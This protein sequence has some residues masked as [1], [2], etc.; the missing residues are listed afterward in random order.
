MRFHEVLETC[1]PRFLLQQSGDDTHTGG[2]ASD[3]WLVETI[4]AGNVY[5][6]R[7]LHVSSEPADW[8][9]NC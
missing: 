5:E 4:G 1:A 8:P 3:Q 6:M 9:V 2:G 7:R